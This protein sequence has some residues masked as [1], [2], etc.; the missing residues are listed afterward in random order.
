VEGFNM[1][2]ES[3]TK[4]YHS[5][6]ASKTTIIRRHHPLIN[7]QLALLTVA[8]KTVTVRLPDGSSMKILRP[9]TDVDSIACTDLNGDSE[10]SVHGLKELLSLFMAL[11][12]RSVD[13]SE[14]ITTE[15]S[16]VEVSD[17]ETTTVGIS[18]T[19]MSGNDMGAA[20][21][22]RQRRAHPTGGTADGSCIGGADSGLTSRQRQPGGE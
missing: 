2:R 10:I 17:D 3:Q 16:T 20:P 18:R 15:Q 13:D 5:N 12:E 19:R 1:G 4:Y 11:R 8:R 9:W 6:S 21:R 22:T 14:M 7:Q